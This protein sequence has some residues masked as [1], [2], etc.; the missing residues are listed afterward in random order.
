MAGVDLSGVNATLEAPMD[1]V[2]GSSTLARANW[3]LDFPD[4]RWKVTAL[5][6]GA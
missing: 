2:L 4:R 3:W 5:L 6:P 1:L